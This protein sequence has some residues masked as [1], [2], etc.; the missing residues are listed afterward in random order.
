MWGEPF[1][2]ASRTRRVRATSAIWALS[3]WRLAVQQ[4]RV[5]RLVSL[6]TGGLPRLLMRAT[7]VD[8]AHRPRP[9]EHGGVLHRHLVMHGL[10]IDER[11]PLGQARVVAQEIADE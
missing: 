2:L 4:P 7:L 9:R 3:P 8:D 1:R 5:G 6:V 10:G 11:D